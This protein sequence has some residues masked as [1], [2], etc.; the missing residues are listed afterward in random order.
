MGLALVPL[1]MTMSTALVPSK[2]LQT[3]RSS[4]IIIVFIVKMLVLL[5]NHLQQVNS[6]H[7][8]IE[9]CTD[10]TLCWYRL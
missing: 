10:P 5:A 9:L 8:N 4:Q 6:H 2:G 1:Y 3:A 7:H